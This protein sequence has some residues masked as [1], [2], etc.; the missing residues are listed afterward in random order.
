MGAR[1]D[2]AS[3]AEGGVSEPVVPMTT[4]KM[5]ATL[6]PGATTSAV[7][8]DVTLAGNSSEELAVCQKHDEAV[9]VF[10]DDSV[11]DPSCPLCFAEFIQ[12]DEEQILA[13][14]WALLRRSPKGRLQGVPL[15]ARVKVAFD[16]IEEICRQ[17]SIDGE[18]AT[19]K[20]YKRDERDARAAA[21]LPATFAPEKTLSRLRDAI[22]AFTEE[23]NR[24]DGR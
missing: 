21:K 13:R 22:D 3:A 18:S 23:F 1:A 11:S 17:W 20:S 15:A 19:E 6:G 2:A 16:L 7:R 14:L 5:V 24:D 10:A 12:R 4:K 8:M 9:V